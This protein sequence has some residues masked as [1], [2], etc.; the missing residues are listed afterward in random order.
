[1]YLSFFCSQR[2][3]SYR[4]EKTRQYYMTIWCVP[5]Y[6]ECILC[7]IYWSEKFLVCQNLIQP[8]KLVTADTT[9]IFILPKKKCLKKTGLVPKKDVFVGNVEW[10]SERKIKNHG[11]GGIRTHATFVTGALNQ[12]LRPLGHATTW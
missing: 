1:M 6:M 10:K 8:N 3:Q 12:R 2:I 4:V 7:T 5:L 11:S 9:I